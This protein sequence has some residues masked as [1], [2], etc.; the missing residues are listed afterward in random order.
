MV[1]KPGPS[2]PVTQPSLRIGQVGLGGITVTHRRAYAEYGLPVVAGYDPDS[3]ARQRFDSDTPG[4]KTYTSLDELLDDEAVDVIDLATP[5][6]PETRL[7]VIRSIA[8]AGKPVLIQKPLGR[9][10]LDA[11]EYVGILGAEGVTAMVNQN[12]CFTPG[13]LLLRRAL[14]SDGVIGAPLIGQISTRFLFDTGEH[15]WF[16]RDDRW[17][18]VGVVVHHLSL[19]QLLFGPPE[20]V[21]AVLG[22]DPGQ[23]VVPTDGF[24]YIS[25]TYASGLHVMLD[26]T[27]TYYGNDEIR[28]QSEK[29]FF[30]GTRGIVDWRPN[31]VPV[32][33]RR[34]ADD[35]TTIAREPLGT[36]V[37]GTWFPNAFG[38]AMEHFQQALRANAE[39]L[40]SVQD[41]LYVMAAVEAV[42]QSHASKASASLAEIMGDRWNPNYGSGSSH[43]FAEWAPPPRTVNL[44]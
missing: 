40:C 22:A 29:V 30:Q 15:P 9:T 23:P 7:D 25:M 5:H 2:M 18:T 28:H 11:V 8:Q 17:W 27:G 24:A 32:L 6:H 42:Y 21:Y 39:P 4:A 3:S 16:G 19:L 13:A 44:R 31:E 33:S 41:N 1:M 12:M 38:L 43:G 20:K 14:V 35:P 10:Y 26:S 36:P 37:Q 34:D